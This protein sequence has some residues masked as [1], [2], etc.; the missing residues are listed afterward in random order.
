MSAHRVPTLGTRFAFRHGRTARRVYE[1]I[2]SRTEEQ[3]RAAGQHGC[4]RHVLRV[5][6]ETGYQPEHAAGIGS[7]IHVGDQ[8][9]IERTRCAKEFRA[10]VITP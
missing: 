1:L 8:W 3:A 10:E 5:V 7:E 9:F 2:A 6:E 4:D